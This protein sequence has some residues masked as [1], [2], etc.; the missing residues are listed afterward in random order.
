[1]EEF[2]E[3]EMDAEPPSAPM[4][5]QEAPHME[6]PAV[7]PASLDAVRTAV[8]AKFEKEDLD[9]P[10]FLRKRGDVV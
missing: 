9:V 10:A 3:P 8:M 6:A 4:V 5:M 7:E 1:V 2:A